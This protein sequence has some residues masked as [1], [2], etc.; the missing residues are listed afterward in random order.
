M[1]PDLLIESLDNR[2]VIL[3]S[4]DNWAERLHYDTVLLTIRNDVLHL[5]EWVKLSNE[6]R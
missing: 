6:H 1:N 4:A 5:A 3:L 2:V